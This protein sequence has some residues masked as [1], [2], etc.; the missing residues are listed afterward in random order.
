MIV[1]NFHKIQN[2]R[3]ISDLFS[4]IWLKKRHTS[5]FLEFVAKSGQN[6]IK[7][8]QKKMQNSM[9]KMKKAEIHFSFA[10]KCWRF[11]AEILRSERCRS[12][13]HKCKSCRSRQ[14]LSNLFQRAL[15]SSTCK[16]LRRYSRER[17][18]QSLQEI[19]N[20][21]GT[22]KRGR[23]NN[24]FRVPLKY[25]FE[26]RG[27]LKLKTSPMHFWRPRQF[28]SVFETTKTEFW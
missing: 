22:W 24:P 26:M 17:A 23:V 4:Q 19:R 21:N 14:E 6:F 13:T 3:Q 5:L 1:N 28:N 20:L 18:S 15:L 16:N 10:K 7:N 9:Q 25:E 12:M 2:F 11:F 8:S 27:Q